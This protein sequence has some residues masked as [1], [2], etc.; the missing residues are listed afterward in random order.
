[1]SR[2]RH[3]DLNTWP[4]SAQLVGAGTGVG[5]QHAWLLKRVGI[6]FFPA[7]SGSETKNGKPSC[8]FSSVTLLKSDPK[9]QRS[10]QLGKGGSPDIKSTGHISLFLNPHSQLRRQSD[11]P[12]GA[13][14]Q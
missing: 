6:I 8:L 1:M 10:V 4:K 2:L 5:S 3:R 9:A 7:V 11:P 13:A 12:G 14:K